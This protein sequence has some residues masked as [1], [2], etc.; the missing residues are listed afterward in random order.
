MEI[1]KDL[2][3]DIIIV[4]I[5]AILTM[6]GTYM[7]FAREFVTRE[8]ASAIAL[9]KQKVLEI[10]IV[11][12]TEGRKDVAIALKENTVAINELRVAIAKIT[13]DKP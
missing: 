9:E 2:Q 11:G 7:L 4:L 3:K 13:H 6:T 12:L 10:E 8:E 5:S 1:G